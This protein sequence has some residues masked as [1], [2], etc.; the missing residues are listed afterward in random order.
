MYWG[1]IKCLPFLDSQKNIYGLYFTVS[2]LFL[3][4]KF[5]EALHFR[6]PTRLRL[7]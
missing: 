7:L 4:W 6:E 1:D 3:A 2:F 5:I